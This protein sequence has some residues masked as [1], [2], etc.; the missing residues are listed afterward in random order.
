MR[1]HHYTIVL[2]L[3]FTSNSTKYTVRDLSNESKRRDPVGS[4]VFYEMMN[5]KVTPVG[6]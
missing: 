1:T 3:T 4:T 2:V 5:Y 6:T